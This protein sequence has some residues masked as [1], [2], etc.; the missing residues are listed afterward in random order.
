MVKGVEDLRTPLQ[1]CLDLET[2][3]RGS[4]AG[5][6]MPQFVVDLPEGGG[7]RLAA[8]YLAYDRKTGISRFVAPSVT[9]G[10]SKVDK[11][12]E[13]HDPLWSLQSWGKNRR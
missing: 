1:T 11:V 7:K 2:Q 8:S 6:M 5:F 9:R 13:Y 12:Y 3:I 4:I 10:T